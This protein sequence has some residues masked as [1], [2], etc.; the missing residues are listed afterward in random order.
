MDFPILL[1]TVL[2]SIYKLLIPSINPL[3]VIGE[4][5]LFRESPRNIF[6]ILISRCATHNRKWGKRDKLISLMVGQAGSN[7]SGFSTRSPHRTHSPGFH[8]QLRIALLSSLPHPPATK[9][10]LIPAPGMKASRSLLQYV[11]SCSTPPCIVSPS[12]GVRRK[13]GSESISPHALLLCFE[14]SVP[15]SSRSSPRA[16]RN[17]ISF[18]IRA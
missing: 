1:I 15:A 12:P 3:P 8:Q 7:R 11:C 6:S 16:F 2:I 14:P 17:S 9:P 4:G 13:S 18:Q 10:N 5:Q